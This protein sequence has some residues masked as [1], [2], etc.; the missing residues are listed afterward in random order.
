MKLRTR[1]FELY[2][3]KYGSLPELARAME[4]ST[5]QIYKVKQDK[6]SI[7]GKF[8]IGTVKPFPNIRWMSFSILAQRGHGM[9]TGNRND[10]SKIL[11]RCRCVL[12]KPKPVVAS[13][14]FTVAKGSNG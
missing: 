14:G 4:I 11:N 5:C 8:I 7:N 9:K 10:L 12:R 1:V 2:K 6:R 3:G 13:P